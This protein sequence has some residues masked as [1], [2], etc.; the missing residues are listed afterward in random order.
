V[1]LAESAGTPQVIPQVRFAVG[2]AVRGPADA[3][4]AALAAAASQQPSSS[5]EPSDSSLRRLSFAQ[6]QFTTDH[7]SIEGR[8]ETVRYQ[9]VASEYNDDSQEDSEELEPRE[10][11]SK[12]MPAFGDL[13]MDQEMEP[14]RCRI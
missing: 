3:Y 11:A 5:E 6:Q 2:S 12:P 14:V 13:T 8:R 9:S 7:D 10:Q 4:E 1:S